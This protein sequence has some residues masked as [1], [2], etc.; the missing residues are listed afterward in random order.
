MIT[1]GGFEGIYEW[2][3]IDGHYEF[4]KITDVISSNLFTF[5]KVSNIYIDS[6]ILKMDDIYEKYK[7]DNFINKVYYLD[8]SDIENYL[9]TI[10]YVKKEDTEYK[11][12]SEKELI[13]ELED[14]DLED[15]DLERLTD[16]TQTLIVEDKEEPKKERVL[17]YDKTI[18][19]RKKL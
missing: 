18:K 3:F 11:L 12:K 4:D 6:V 7:K 14:K 1:A 17:R 10:D 19:R 8:L 13:K 5:P 2:E 16:T 9:T 15:K